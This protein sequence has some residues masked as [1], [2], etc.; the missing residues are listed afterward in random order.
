MAIK[1]NKP[2]GGR[3]PY[4]VVDGLR[5]FIQDEKINGE[6]MH[7]LKARPE[8]QPIFDWTPCEDY[9]EAVTQAKFVINMIEKREEYDETGINFI[10]DPFNTVYGRS[11]HCSKRLIKKRN[12]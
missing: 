11:L 2:G 8:K 12:I 1:F 10:G 5:Y 6:W 9:L 7:I 4:V 3:L